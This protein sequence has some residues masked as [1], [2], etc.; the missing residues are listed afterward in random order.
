[1]ATQK[2]RR[3]NLNLTEDIVGL[4]NRAITGGR[5]GSVSEYVRALIVCERRRSGD[6]VSGITPKIR[7]GRPKAA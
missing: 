7:Q 6:K 5:Y 2:V 4:A 3:I 1:M